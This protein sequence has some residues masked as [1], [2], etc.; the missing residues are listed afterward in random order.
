MNSVTPT[1]SRAGLLARVAIVSATGLIWAGRSV[2]EVVGRPAYWNPATASDVVA[3]VAYSAALFLT[4]ASLLILAEFA[5]PRRVLALVIVMAAAGCATAGAAN[6]LEDGL[7]LS[8][9][10][11]VYV[12]GALVGGVGMVLTALMLLASPARKLAFVPALGAIAM[13]TFSAGGGVIAVPAW[14]GLAALLIRDRQ[15]R[16]FPQ[17]AVTETAVAGRPRSRRR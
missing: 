7:D 13:F 6:G 9:F 16:Q 3:V 12:A 4:A 17:A 2:Q 1:R 10:G 5:R 14:L 8:G 15:A 11:S